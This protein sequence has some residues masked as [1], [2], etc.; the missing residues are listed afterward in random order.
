VLSVRAATC[1]SF[2]RIRQEHAS[3]SR[4][5]QCLRSRRLADVRG[6][7]R[8]VGNLNRIVCVR[9]VAVRA[10]SSALGLVW[11]R[12]PTTF[13]I[14]LRCRRRQ[15]RQCFRRDAEFPPATASAT[16]D[17]IWIGLLPS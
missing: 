8:P 10:A 12:D 17:G 7:G 1:A 6:R 4:P 5:T 11:Q 13:A 14:P 16:K 3:E 9:R 2:A 15:G